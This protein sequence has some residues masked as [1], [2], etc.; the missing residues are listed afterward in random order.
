MILLEKRMRGLTTDLSAAVSKLA[1]NNVAPKAVHRLRTTI[2][3]IES[4]VSYAHPDL[5]KKLERSLEK[6]ADLRKRAGRVRDMDVQI[7][8]LDSVANGS[9]AKDRKTLA[10][11]LGKKR[12]RQTQRLVLVVRKLQESKFFARMNRIA[13]KAGAVT[14]GENRPLAPTEEAKAQLGEMAAD[15]ASHQKLKISRLH[16]A[17]ISLKRI[18]Y[19]AELAEESPEQKSLIRELKTVQDAVGD[20]HD[21]LELT[22]TAE[23]RFSDR[24]NCALLREIRALL[25]ARHATATSSLTNLF[26]SVLAPARKPPRSEQSV[27]A[28]ARHA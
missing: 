22:S 3:R 28:F 5:D 24:V 9:T 15:F 10:E 23:K 19:L 4:L 13:E 7:G 18:R 27:R 1:E 11:L 26:A 2:R 25:A 8:L 12:D 20:W 21:W 6:M 17:R 16:D 14:H